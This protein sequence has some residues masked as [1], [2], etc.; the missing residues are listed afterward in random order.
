MVSITIAERFSLNILVARLFEVGSFYGF[1]F[2]GV[3]YT[4]VSIS[5]AFLPSSR[6]SD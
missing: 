1:I 2:F 5:R 3:S 6:L 4:W